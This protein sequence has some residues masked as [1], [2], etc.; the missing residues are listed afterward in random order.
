MEQDQMTDRLTDNY[1]HRMKADLKKPGPNAA[2][3]VAEEHKAMSSLIDELIDRRAADRRESKRAKQYQKLRHTVE[4]LLAKVEEI[5]P[6]EPE[7]I[8]YRKGV[9]DC[10]KDVHRRRDLMV[11]MQHPAYRA[12][13]DELLIIFEGNRARE[14][15]PMT[16]QLDSFAPPEPA[17]RLLWRNT[18]LPTLGEA[19]TQAGCDL[20]I[21][22]GEG[23]QIDRAAEAI[24][25]ERVRVDGRVSINPLLFVTL[26]QVI[27]VDGVSFT[28]D[29][30][31]VPP[32]KE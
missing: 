12:A 2:A 17:K 8:G 19:V 1:L 21:N 6:L 27:T 10:I 20:L 32:T 25:Q 14:G 22:I 28:L 29:G 9:S 4:Y 5:E 13:L 18:R 11:D 31:R 15:K 7:R 16:S 24:T 30:Y 26:G 23:S 3:G